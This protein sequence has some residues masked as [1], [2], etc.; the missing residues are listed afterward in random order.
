MKTIIERAQ[1]AVA[2]ANQA[3]EVAAKS[4]G[5]HVNDFIDELGDRNDDALYALGS[6]SSAI[7]HNDMDCISDDII[8]EIY[9]YVIPEIIK[10]AVKKV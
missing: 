3:M 9:Y 7:D 1:E 10:N 5:M 6:L 2:V 8:S 4:L